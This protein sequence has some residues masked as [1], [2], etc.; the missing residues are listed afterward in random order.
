[1]QTFVHFNCLFVYSF[2]SVESWI[3]EHMVNMTTTSHTGIID[4]L[5]EVQEVLHIIDKVVAT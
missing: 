3:T 5:Q 4:D 1:M 2:A